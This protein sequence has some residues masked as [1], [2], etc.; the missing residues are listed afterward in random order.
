MT[1]RI[2]QK[3]PGFFATTRFYWVGA[4]LIFLLMAAYAFSFLLLPAQLLTA[5]WIVAC[6]ADLV[7]MHFSPRRGIEGARLAPVKLS[8]GDQNEIGLELVSRY[9]F[10]L[11][12]EVIDEMPEELQMREHRLPI[13]LKPN[14]L[15]SLTY[16]IRPVQRGEYEFGAINVMVRS[17]TGLFELRFRIAQEQKVAVYPSF[18]MMR[19]YDLLTISN[20]LSEVGVRA[21][22]NLG[23]SMDFEQI[24]DYVAGDDVRALNWKATARRNQLMVN[25]FQQERSQNV[26]CIIDKGRSMQM[27][28]E[29]MTLLDYSINAVLSFS[30][31]VMR[32]YDRPG[33]LT[34]HTK[35]DTFLKASSN[36]RQLKSI[37]DTLYREKTRFQE[38]DFEKLFL[39]VRHGIGQRSLLLLFT[40]FE[41]LP[42]LQRRLPYLRAM[43]RRHLLVVVFFQN[44]GLQE[45]AEKPAE[46][47]QEVAVGY[48]ANR[49]LSEKEQIVAELK[50]HG[51][52]G[53]LTPPSE[54]TI[55]VINQYLQLKAQNRI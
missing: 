29:G 50:R 37:S 11:K 52:M 19:K 39:A 32:K 36:Q 23:H 33:L 15:E 45:L 6:L 8:N 3:N 43:A 10:A 31:I 5:V 42:S 40:N 20:R 53:L 14:I 2:L 41:G 47:F 44:T 38:P 17:L 24:K 16:A 34:F 35:V 49:L 1:E 48:M 27:P 46:S 13:S 18:L 30:N 25:H 51:I 55:N 28:F 12:A 7:V 22:R 9:P 4:V 26:Y 54:L 21:V